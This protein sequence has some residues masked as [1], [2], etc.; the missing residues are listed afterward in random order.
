MQTSDPTERILRPDER[1]RY[2]MPPVPQRAP[3]RKGKGGS[4]SG[5]IVALGAL[6]VVAGVAGAAGIHAMVQ[7]NPPEPPVEPVNHSTED[8]VTGHDQAGSGS[9]GHSYS[10]N[11][12]QV[13]DIEAPSLSEVAF[14]TSP[15]DAMSFNEAFASARSEVGPHG[16][17]EWRGQ[18]YGTYYASEWNHLPESYREQFSSHDWNALA[19]AS[20]HEPMEGPLPEPHEPTVTELPD[21]RVMISL[22]DA[23]TGET[24]YYYPDGEVVPVFDMNGEVI[25][26]VNKSALDEANNCNGG[27]LSILPNGQAVVYDDPAMLKNYAGNIYNTEAEMQSASVVDPEHQSQSSDPDEQMLSYADPEDPDEDYPE[28]E[29]P[30]D[31]DPILAMVSDDDDDIDD[32]ELLAAIDEDPVMLDVDDDV[33]MAILADDQDEMA[34]IPDGLADDDAQFDHGGA[35]MDFS[36]H[37]DMFHDMAYND[38]HLDDVDF[39]AGVDGMDHDMGFD[40]MMSD[41]MMMG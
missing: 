34:Y 31:D 12:S 3:K 38:D 32:G 18:Y 5:R 4:E 25:A 2:N 40:D 39:S 29:Y 17:F 14:A 33:E 28:G 16:V 30:V 41:D 15:N 1:A 21:G 27:I 7:R 37:D 20:I 26:M 8:P 22:R 24:V 10:A 13:S 19:N 6:G 9:H 23:T 35:D 36:D 11:S